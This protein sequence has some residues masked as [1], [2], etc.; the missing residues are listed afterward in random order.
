MILSRKGLDDDVSL[1]DGVFNG[2]FGGDEEEDFVIGEGVVM[3]S[4]SLERSTKSC[5]GRIMWKRNKEDD[6]EDDEDGEGD[7]YLFWSNKV[8]KIVLY[9]SSNIK[10]HMA[11]A[12]GD[13]IAVTNKTKDTFPNYL[14]PCLHNIGDFTSQ[15]LIV[16]NN[17]L[18]LMTVVSD[19][20]M[21]FDLNEEFDV[22]RRR[23]V[24][25]IGTTRRNT[26]LQVVK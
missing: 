11:Q 17:N 14:D 16:L 25:L 9:G 15:D 26:I 8:S 5:L 10:E 4:S 18:L 24:R 22:I 3:S 2:V 21:S 19:N 12:R 13:M 23:R 6:C 20:T 7:D 1:V